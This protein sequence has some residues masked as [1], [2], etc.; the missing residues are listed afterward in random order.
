MPGLY[1]GEDDA[2]AMTC[3]G[4]NHGENKCWSARM[5]CV[6]VG[7][8]SPVAFSRLEWTQVP[9]WWRRRALCILPTARLE[10]E[11]ACQSD[12]DLRQRRVR[13]LC[14]PRNLHLEEGHLYVKLQLSCT[15]GGW[16]WLGFKS[17]ASG[18][19]IY[20]ADISHPGTSISQRIK[21]NDV[22][23]KNGEFQVWADGVSI[24]NI[25]S[26]IFVRDEIS[27]I[28]SFSISNSLGS[29]SACQRTPLFVV[30]KLKRSSA[31]R[32]LINPGV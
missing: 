2:I 25:A 21:L 8:Y 19:L 16:A 6:T 28:L 7:T 4:G 3:S 24:M 26:S 9:P 30:L 23:Q 13:H 5:M 14:R 20:A 12:Q 31:V 10:R 29:C 18:L 1:G 11:R 22:G 17:Q 27:L 15:L 32:S